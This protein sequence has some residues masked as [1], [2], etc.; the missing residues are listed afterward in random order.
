M[1]DDQE[2]L[3][4]YQRLGI[5]ERARATIDLIRS[6]EPSRRVGG[7]RG[8]VT[9]LYPSR[10]M[11]GTIQF[12]SHRVEL[13]FVYEYEHDRGVL[14]YYDQPPPIKLLHKGEDKNGKERNIGY[15][16]TPD[17]FVIRRDSAGY[18]ECKTE[19]DL[20]RLAEKSPNRFVRGEDG[21]WRC[22]PGEE[23]AA[24]YGLYYRVRSSAE[25]DWTFQR[26]II[27]I[28]DYFRA[29]S[30]AVAETARQ[31]ISQAV[32]AEPGLTL[33]ELLLRTEGSASPDDV[34]MM[35]ATGELCVDWRAAALAEPDT[36]LVFS[37]QETATAYSRVVQIPAVTAANLIHLVDCKAGAKLTW[38]NQVWKIVNVGETKVGLL[39]EDGE[40]VGL[41]GSTFDELVRR[42]EIVGVAGGEGG[43][44]AEVRER[45]NSAT[46]KDLEIANQRYELIF[47]E[48]GVDGPVESDVSERTLRRYR[49]AYRETEELYGCGY[50]GLLP[51]RDGDGN[52]QGNHEPK[53]PADTRQLTDE[54]IDN[55]YET[56][57]Q[58]G[59][60]SVYAILKKECEKRGIIV[61]SYKTFAKMVKGRPLYKKTYKR[62][63]RRAA[64]KFK[65]PYWN[66]DRTT[67]RHGD[68]PFEI[69]H[70]DHTEL[71]VELVDSLTGR[72]LGRPWV[73]FMVDAYSRR[74]LVV[75]V[76]YD[77]PSYR[78]CMMALRECVRIYG[79]LPQF[80]VVDNAPEFRC[81]YF[82]TLLARYEC[83][84]KYRP[85]AE[86]KIGAVCERLFGTTNTQFVNNLTGNTQLTKTVRVVTKSV[87][88]KNLAIWIMDA[89]YE[90]LCEYAHD[91]YNTIEHPA[92]GMTPLQAFTSRMKE[93][94]ERK[95]A[96]I[97]Y[98]EDFRM[99][100]M[101][102][103][104]KGTAKVSPGKGV[105]INNFYYSSDEFLNPDVENK[106]VPVRF[107]PYDAG[108][109]YALV[110]GR[111]ARCLSDHYLTLSG[112][113]EKELAQAADELRRRHR[114]HSR[115]Y[116]SLT[117]KKLADFL[118][119]VEAEEILLLQRAR[120]RESR[121]II[122]RIN[123]GFPGAGG[124]K[125]SQAVAGAQAGEARE[126]GNDTGHAA[127][128]AGRKAAR[129]RM[130]IEE[131]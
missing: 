106:S 10:K 35:I 78:T 125:I 11:N 31:A 58:Q 30:R 19:E 34:Y 20:R 46:R 114:L 56:L 95:G 33:R 59:M 71:D 79:R 127:P 111:W 63:G 60:F 126:A 121:G 12:E 72:N 13:P 119:S 97:P 96:G 25:I 44:S 54:F 39:A 123:G 4:W 73:T 65:T 38:D 29:R 41:P 90:K 99:M 62:K 124:P 82:Q 45:F 1:L 92:L 84:I 61:P 107:D 105:K 93:T 131:F 98:D 117:A 88:P 74:L 7:G 26:N 130:V 53:L 89:L 48:F 113:S 108:V 128:A 18:E 120:D 57:K 24:P 101:P 103:T 22:P 68:R 43:Q 102:T 77:S 52:G 87:N 67:P 115:G 42:G 118:T 129:A 9:G 14:E 32:E 17:F 94:G 80:A 2:I 49:A 5:H 109:A 76:T 27:F 28:E 40:Y 116:F 66:L 83:T 110:R 70:I 51:D 81:T 21:V 15:I 6:S 50:V 55:K 85:K 100:T 122:Q 91:V 37:D 104:D 36:V 47:P 23:A 75:Y 64:Y 3:R 8:N 69:V 16:H 112:R 86:S